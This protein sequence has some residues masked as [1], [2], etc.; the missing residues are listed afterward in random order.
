MELAET[1]WLCRELC[2]TVWYCTELYGDTRGGA[3]LGGSR[4]QL[5]HTGLFFW[6][7]HAVGGS[8]GLFQRSRN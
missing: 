2:G 7:L 8:Q 5:S 4:V 1:A 3:F 6:A